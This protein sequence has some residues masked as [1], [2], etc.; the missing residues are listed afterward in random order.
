MDYERDTTESGKN[1]RPSR[2]GADSNPPR[3]AP[4]NQ[5]HQLHEPASQ[6]PTL[7]LGNASGDIPTLFE[8]PDC[9]SEGTK[10]RQSSRTV[11]YDIHTPHSGPPAGHID[12]PS[13]NFS[14]LSAPPP[15]SPD[16][17]APSID[18]VDLDQ[19]EEAFGDVTQH[20]SNNERIAAH[21]GSAKSRWA[22]IP[23]PKWKTRAG[24]VVIAC[25]LTSLSYFVGKLS[26]SPEPIDD[27]IPGLMISEDQSTEVDTNTLQVSP[28]DPMT[29][30]PR[31][32]PTVGGIVNASAAP[33]PH[34]SY[35]QTTEVQPSLPTPATASAAAVGGENFFP[36]NSAGPIA[37][38]TP[39]AIDSAFNESSNARGF[40][41][42]TDR[43]VS[44]RETTP[45]NNPYG[46]DL[47]SGMADRLE[48]DDSLHYTETP[49]PIGNFLDILKVWEESE[50]R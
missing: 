45:T 8:L 38:T 15:H 35:D 14:K 2:G 12:P 27:S 29:E 34:P 7:P 18:F 37:S 26:R 50:L 33:A 43:V 21:S 31:E 46:N 24:I 13:G 40:G 1:T 16:G 3:P 5:N 47:P 48:L 10:R 17:H 20:E 28:A 49:H 6:E 44:Y 36:A 30:P 22:N 9:T 32:S 4:L 23:Q 39:N 42:S 25:V 19:A 11:L 41:N